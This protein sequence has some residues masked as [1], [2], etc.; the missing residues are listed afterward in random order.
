MCVCVCVNYHHWSVANCGWRVTACDGQFMGEGYRRRV[1]KEVEGW[2]KDKGRE[3]ES[4]MVSLNLVGL[5]L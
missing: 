1:G 5:G 4:L 2:G 3:R